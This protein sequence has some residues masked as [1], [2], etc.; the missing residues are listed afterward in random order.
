MPV[1]DSITTTFG[2]VGTGGFGIR[3]DSI[4]SYSPSLQWIVTVFMILSGVNFSA[5]YLLLCRRFRDAFSIEEVRIYFVVI[6]LAVIFI[7]ANISHLYADMAQTV[8]YAFFQV[9]SIIT[10]TGY[11]TTD[12]NTWPEFS[13]TVLVVLMFI[14]ACAGSTGGGIKVSRFVLLFKTVKKELSLIIHPREIKKIRMDS[15]IV[16]HEVIRS[17]NVYLAIYFVV[18]LTSVLLVSWDGFSFTTNFTAVAATLNNIGPGLDSVGP[19]GN[20]AHFS[21]FSK[22]V[23]MFDMLAGRLELFPVMILLHPR[24]WR[25]RS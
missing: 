10:T 23:L 11:A 6:G 15:H 22:L 25:S 9:G 19:T 8:R 13:K 7:S 20:F 21:I 17:T 3:G 14:G 1:F 12:F 4:A 24:T 18:L 16:E 2:T 5:Y